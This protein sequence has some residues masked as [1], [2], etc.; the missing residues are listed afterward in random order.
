MAVLSGILL[1]RK[2][3]NIKFSG[4]RIKVEKNDT[5]IQFTA[6]KENMAFTYIN[7]D[8][9]FVHFGKHTII[10]ISTYNGRNFF[11]FFKFYLFIYF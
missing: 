4:K 5:E 10:H 2:H 1:S 3:E 11:L 6:R 9:T 7:M 8:V